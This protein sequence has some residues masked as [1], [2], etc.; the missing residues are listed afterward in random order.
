M[1]EERKL[2]LQM[3]AEGKVT[4]VEGDMLLQAIDESERATGAASPEQ[5]RAAAP[6]LQGP[7]SLGERIGEKVRRAMERAAE[8]EGRAARAAE[9]A[10][11]RAAERAGRAAERAAE[12]AER[13]ADR[14]SR[15]LTADVERARII[16]VGICIDREAVQQQ[17]RFT[18]PAQPG[19]RI[20]LENRVGDVS[21][22]YVEGAEIA[23]EV[24]KTVW[25]STKADAEERANVTK[26]YCQREGADVLLG[27]SHP[28]IT[29]TGLMILKDTRLD[30]VILVPHGTNLEICTK[31]GDLRV[32]AGDEVGNWHLETK[33]GDAD[34][35]V[36]AA[37][38][39]R[40]SLQTKVGSVL[41]QVPETQPGLVGSGAGEIRVTSKTGDIRLHN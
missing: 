10:A 7:V 30:Y 20:C 28:N 17:E 32:E 39:F 12:K 22:S 25:G 27:V 11:D 4:P 33:V 23:V 9:R 8:A 40:H 19:D 36:G 13:I 38:G 29:A 21:V 1:S 3:V 37:A 26:L 16:K 15:K 2:I 35:R 14:V 34:L 6:G 18:V 41:V 24:R 5:A 31:V